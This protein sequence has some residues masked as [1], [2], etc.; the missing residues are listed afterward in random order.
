VL[1]DAGDREIPSP[2]PNLAPL[3]VGDD[4]LLGAFDGCSSGTLFGTIDPGSGRLQI[5]RRQLT[6]MVPT[7]RS[8][9]QTRRA[10]DGSVRADGMESLD[11]GGGP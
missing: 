1:T 4:G 2:V 3:A 10:Q 5:T 9:G 6:E 11:S 7:A 8:P